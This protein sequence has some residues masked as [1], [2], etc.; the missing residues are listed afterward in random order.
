MVL[1]NYFDMRLR[2]YRFPVQA[3]IFQFPVLFP[4]FAVP[5]PSICSVLVH[6]IS[7][8]AGYQVLPPV[9]SESTLGVRRQFDFGEIT[10]VVDLAPDFR[11]VRCLR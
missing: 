3:T 4:A 5:V 7:V 1:V 10:F 8:H 11:I 9:R 6:P 2:K